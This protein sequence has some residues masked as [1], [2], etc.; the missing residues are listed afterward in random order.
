M[1]RRA[2]DDRW[3]APGPPP[4]GMRESI[5]RHDSDPRA[6]HRRE[7]VACARARG[8]HRVGGHEDKRRGRFRAADRDLIPHENLPWALPPPTPL[9]AAPRRDREARRARAWTSAR[10]RPP[11]W[12]VRPTTP[13]PSRRVSQPLSPPPPGPPPPPPRKRLRR[14]VDDDAGMRLAANF[15]TAKTIWCA[16]V[17]T[18]P[19]AKANFRRRR[20]SPP[21]S[22]PHVDELERSNTPSAT[23]VKSDSTVTFALKCTSEAPSSTH[24]NHAAGRIAG[25]GATRK[26]DETSSAPA[27]RREPPYPGTT[28]RTRARARRG[29]DPPSVPP[30]RVRDGV[31]GGCAGGV[32]DADHDVGAWRRVRGCVRRERRVRAASAV[33][34]MTPAGRTPTTPASRRAMT[35]SS[36]TPLARTR[37]SA[38][39]ASAA[40]MAAGTSAGTV[41][42][43][44]VDISGHPLAVVPDVDPAASDRR[45]GAPSMVTRSIISSCAW[46]VTRRT[47]PSPG[48]GG[49]RVIVAHPT[50]YP[51]ARRDRPASSS[52]CCR[53][54]SGS[55]GVPVGAGAT[56]LDRRV[57]LHRVRM[58]I[59][60]RRRRLR[61]RAP[62]RRHPA[63]PP[64]GALQ[65][66]EDLGDLDTPTA[67][68]PEAA[69]LRAKRTARCSPPARSPQLRAR[70]HGLRR[71]AAS[72]KEERGA[73][74]RVH[75]LVRRLLRPRRVPGL[76]ARRRARG[77]EILKLPEGMPAPRLSAPARVPHLP[78]RAPLRSR[79]VSTVR[80][81]EC[82]GVSRV[83]SV[84]GARDR[85]ADRAGGCGCEQS[86]QASSSKLPR[87]R[88]TQTSTS[89]TT[90]SSRRR[91]NR[92]REREE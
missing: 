57:H 41:E 9:R 79:G 36:A 85:G 91:T 13:P 68:G 90:K 18:P 73:R 38:R 47:S 34:G 87:R 28:N 75:R 24:G 54:T 44:D 46:R 51:P 66:C 71:S 63:S 69:S 12:R 7:D 53:R 42:A 92:K 65:N 59:R 21:S 72:A 2:S 84:P 74:P 4:E 89:K 23:T 3:R 16:C 11:R 67:S 26:R 70:D 35:S 30:P 82:R 86:V 20:R 80:Q 43:L 61:G 32:P 52:R 55:R 45:A 81:V 31:P 37:A 88:A 50:T 40:G 10:A 83:R 19:D 22:S 15:P 56:G 49:R 58:G 77:A 62:A 78:G 39:A 64:G 27:V 17:G 14:L 1:S 29:E 60:R 25:P 33:G 5:R 6:E 48:G 76:R 8:G